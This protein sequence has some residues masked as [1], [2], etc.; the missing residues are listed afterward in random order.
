MDILGS[1]RASAACVA[2]VLSH[3]TCTAAEFELPIE[4]RD[5]AWF[6]PTLVTNDQPICAAILDAERATFFAP[7][8]VGPEIPELIELTSDHGNMED[9]S[10]RKHTDAKVPLLLFGDKNIRR[11]FQTD[12]RDLSGIAPAISK[13]LQIN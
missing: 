13:L 6:A 1:I 4:D 11:E 12:I 9:L 10:T 2:L 5:S 3:L 7:D 8:D